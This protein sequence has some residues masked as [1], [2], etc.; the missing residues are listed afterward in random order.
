MSK[1]LKLGKRSIAVILSVLLLLPFMLSGAFAANLI[2]EVLL[3]PDGIV[4]LQ[5]V[6][7]KS[8]LFSTTHQKITRLKITFMKLT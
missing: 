8:M 5:K 4:T 1:F 2:D 7:P 6:L 3:Y